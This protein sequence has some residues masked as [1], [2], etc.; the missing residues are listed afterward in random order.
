[1][2]NFQRTILK[3]GKL[4][5]VGLHTGKIANVKFIP[6]VINH[7]IKFQRIDVNDSPIIEANVDYVTSVERGTTISKNN[8]NISTVEHLLA[9]IVGLQIDNILIQ[10]DSRIYIYGFH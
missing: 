8:V 4:S 5:D 3:E 9:A 1:M 2:R 7:G 10:I 6:A